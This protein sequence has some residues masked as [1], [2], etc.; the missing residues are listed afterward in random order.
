MKRLGLAV[1][2]VAL[3]VVSISGAPAPGPTVGINVV[4]RIAPDIVTLAQ[5]SVYGKVR[6]VI[7]EINGV[8]MQAAEKDLVAIRALPFVEAAGVDQPRGT[9]P[10]QVLAATDF[11]DGF[12]T[13][14][15]DAIDVTNLQAGPDRTIASNGAGVY[16][17]V[18]DTGLLNT[19]RFY[20]PEDRIN[21]DYARSFGGGG[22]DVGF[23]SSQPNKW[24]RDQNSHGTHVT[25]TILG[26]NL[27]GTPINGVAPW[28]QSSP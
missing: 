2:V 10:V 24:E 18:L 16:V 17:A 23:V 27:L 21:T 9:G 25:S 1:L 28:P 26:Y 7:P 12:N 3:A 8:T 14:N 20:F 13:W 15:L 22:G 5:L 4:L 19:W 6:D 11:L